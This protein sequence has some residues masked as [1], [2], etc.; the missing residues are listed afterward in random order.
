MHRGQAEFGRL[1]DRLGDIGGVDENLDRVRRRPVEGERRE[2]ALALGPPDPRRDEAGAAVDPD[3]DRAG[4][5]ADIAGQADRAIGVAADRDA[6]D[7]RRA[8]ARGDEIDDAR[9]RGKSVIETGR[10]FQHLDPVHR[11]DRLFDDVDHRQHAIP[12]H[13]GEIVE[14]D[15]AYRQIAVDAGVD[16]RLADAGGVADRIVERLRLLGVEQGAGQHRHGQ[17]RVDQPCVAECAGL[18]IIGAEAVAPIGGDDDIVTGAILGALR[19]RCRRKQ[20]SARDERHRQQKRPRRAG[21]HDSNHDD[22]PVQVI[23]DASDANDLQ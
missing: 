14:R 18:H 17:R 9:W 4:A 19:D 3:A 5:P 10:P 22:P 1:G 16:L 6:G 2:A 13:V 12:P 21:L 20:A 8:R 11:L 7:G 15:A 23:I